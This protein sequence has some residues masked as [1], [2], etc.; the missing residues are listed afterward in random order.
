MLLI[1]EIILTISAWRRGW[2]AWALLP[3][4]IAFGVAF[5]IGFV[6][7]ANGGSEG[8]VVGIAIALDV[9]C[10]AVLIGMIAKPHRKAQDAL[11]EAK[12]TTDAPIIGVN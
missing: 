7:G 10:I 9:V 2:K 5:I 6:A 11:P 8:G 12:Q 3:T 4:A 1:L